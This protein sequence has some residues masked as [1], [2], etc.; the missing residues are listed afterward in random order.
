MFGRYFYT[1]VRKLISFEIIREFSET[2]VSSDDVSVSEIIGIGIVYFLIKYIH[3]TGL[4]R[5]EI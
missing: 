4:D 5:P 2:A 3:F 1:V